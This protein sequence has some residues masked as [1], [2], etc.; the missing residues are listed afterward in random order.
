MSG[1]LSSPGIGS[2]LDVKSIVAELTAVESKPVQLLA[3]QQKTVQ[4]KLSSFGLLKNYLGNLKDAAVRLSDPSL[5]KSTAATSSNAAVAT[6]ASSAN[7]TPGSYHLQVDRLAQAQTLVSAPVADSKADLGAGTLRIE[8]GTWSDDAGSFTAQS[9][10]NP[11]SIALPDTPSSLDAIR[12]RIN[13]AK[14]GVTASVLRDATGA[15]LVVKSSAT[16]AENAVRITASGSQDGDPAP[17]GLAALAYDPAAGSN[18]L[19]RAQPG[20]NA[21]VTLNGVAL[22]SPGNVLDGAVDGLTITLQQ[23]GAATELKVVD[24]TA[25]MKK[26]IANF[27]AAYNDATSYIAGQTAYDAANRKGQPLQGDAVTMQLQRQLATALRDSTGASTRLPTLVAVGVHLDANNALVLDDRKVDAALADPSQAAQA[28]AHVDVDNPKNSGFGVR[29]A[30]LARGMLGSDG[31]LTRGSQALSDR[32][33]S[34]QARQD[35]MTER[36]N[37]YQARLLKQYSALDQTVSAASG[38]ASY[39][40]QQMALLA[41]NS[42]SG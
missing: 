7:S 22:S 11:V 15:R 4:A 19:S 25:A 34:T 16:G 6:V 27:A 21:S 5:W 23:A 3:A 33:R 18:G 38:Q 37:Q 14:A 31:A 30:D 8:L 13:A 29:F 39:V 10:T 20:Q 32:I 40:A 26:A 41:K 12:E 1:T 42:R 9:G 24:D 28:F 36:V 17:P 35:Q 2:K